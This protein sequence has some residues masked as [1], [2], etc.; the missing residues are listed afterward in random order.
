MHPPLV[1]NNNDNVIQTTCQKRLGIIL[2]TR[3]SFEKHLETVLC[4]IN[5]TIGLIRKLQNLLPRTAL[6]TLYKAFVRPHLDYGDIIYDQAHNA[7]FHRGLFNTM[8]A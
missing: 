6:I 1:F 8:S 3:L 2:D 4:K 5:K 7:S